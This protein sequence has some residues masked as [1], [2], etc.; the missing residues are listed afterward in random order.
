MR[1]I[2]KDASAYLRSLGTFDLV[3]EFSAMLNRDTRDN[4]LEPTSGYQTSVLG[5]VSPKGLGSTESFYRVEARGSYYTNF[6]DKALIWH[7]GA[8]AGAIDTFNGGEVPLYE[9]YFLGGGDRCAA[10]RTA[11][12]VPVGLQR[13]QHRRQLDADSHTELTHPIWS[14]I[15]GAIS[16]DAGN[17]WG[18]AY[19]FNLHGINVGVG[20]GLRIKVPMLNAPVRL[21]LAYPV[22]NNQDDLDSKLRFH[23][24]MGFTW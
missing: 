24:N 14:F 6:F 9:R 7:L 20:Y 22:V 1:G 5:A 19:N 16:L 17:V 13:L 11:R 4:L 12:C 2:A 18:D 21:D 15:R 8:H 10:S 3:S 23:F